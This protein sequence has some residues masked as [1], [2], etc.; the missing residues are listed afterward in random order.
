M[1]GGWKQAIDMSF[2]NGNV[3]E[4]NYFLKALSNASIML[5]DHEDSLIWSR[6]EKEGTPSTKLAYISILEDNMVVFLTGCIE[7]SRKVIYF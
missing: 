3:C 2:L 5:I 7:R 1:C 4:W 6:N